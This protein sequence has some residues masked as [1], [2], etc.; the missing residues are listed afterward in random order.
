MFGTFHREMKVAG[1]FM[2]FPT[3]EHDGGWWNALILDESI[4]ALI[5]SMGKETRKLLS[6]DSPSLCLHCCTR[7]SGFRI[8]S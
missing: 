4:S 3:I 2:T 6:T 1:L 7:Y 8:G 5:D